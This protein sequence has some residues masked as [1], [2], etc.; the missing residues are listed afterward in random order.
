MG[1]LKQLRIADYDLDGIRQQIIT[2]IAH[3]LHSNAQPN[4]AK[5]TFIKPIFVSGAPGI[6]KTTL[7]MI[8]DEALQRL[9]PGAVS[10][11]KLV[12][13]GVITGY[14]PY[15]KPLTVSPLRLFER[16][17][18]V[19]SARD[20]NNILRH[21]TYDEETY[22][23]NPKALANFFQHLRG[24]VVLVDEAEIEGYVYFAEKLAQQGILILF[25]S[26]LGAAQ[27]RLAPE[28]FTAVHLTGID[29]RSGDIAK[30]CLPRGA[31]PLFDQVATLERLPQPLLA[32]AD[33]ALTTLQGL[34]VVHLAW[35][36]LRNKPLM[37]DDFG[38][39]FR[40]VGAHYV[41]LDTVPFFADP[42]TYEIGLTVLGH[43]ARFVNFVDAIHDA[44]LPLLVRGTHEQVLDSETAG[45]DLEAALLAYDVKRG[46][47]EGKT[48]II[49]WGRCLSRLRSREAFNQ[50]LTQPP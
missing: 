46:G 22:G 21:W 35:H 27:V 42:S 32:G 7:L 19:L 18:A 30:V 49:E 48:A 5:P 36:E 8:L 15:K 50:R 10:V 31:H 38:H 4:K 9:E 26:N 37:K 39:F 20:W 41:L 44:A 3:N 17:T 6:G 23:E 43:L 13:T 47:N 24:R 45:R 28:R 40:A 16:Q 33:A 14:F 2:P 34:Q 12:T 25:T 1:E 11:R 29:H